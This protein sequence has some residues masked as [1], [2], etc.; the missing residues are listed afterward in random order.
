MEFNYYSVRA[1][2]RV[3]FWTA[4]LLLLGWFTLRTQEAIFDY[5]CRETTIR[6]NDPDASTL[7][8][9]AVNNCTGN[10]M[11]AVDDLVEKYGETVY[12]GQQIT[13]ITKP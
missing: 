5:S 11:S 1:V 9:V 10:I 4:I 3:F 12:P 7:W 2:A 8:D 13:T 6:I